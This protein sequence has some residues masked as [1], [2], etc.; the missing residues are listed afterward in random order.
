[1]ALWCQFTSVELLS[2]SALRKNNLVAS[3]W[4]HR[5]CCRRQALVNKQLDFDATILS[6]SF[7][8]RVVT[9][10]IQFT[11][12]IRR[13]DATERDVV[14]LYE[15][16]NNSICTALT[17][18]SITSN[19]A[20]GVGITGDFQNIDLRIE[21]L[22]RNFVELCFFVGHQNR[23]ASL[24]VYGS[25]SLRFVVIECGDALVCSVDAGDCC[26]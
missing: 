12:S 21:C 9:N 3:T 25:D 10:W 14:T 13:D 5:R 4:I 24:E 6:T 2:T 15:V 23:A 22:G 1:M 17:E 7:F 8:R 11:V 18:C 26:I 19:A 16:A 20:S